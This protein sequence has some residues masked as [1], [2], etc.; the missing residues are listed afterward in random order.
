MMIRNWLINHKALLITFGIT[1]V[2]FTILTSLQIKVLLNNLE[3]LQYYVDTGE[4]SKEAYQYG[5]VSLINL[6]V[7]AVWVALFLILFWRMI[8]PN[9]KTVKNAFFLGELEFL[10]KMPTSIRKELRRK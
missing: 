6:I 5:F 4:L 1:S 7:G 2:L 9:Y 8:F 10:I 3:V